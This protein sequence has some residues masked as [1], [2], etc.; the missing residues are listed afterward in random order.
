MEKG[1]SDLGNAQTPPPRLPVARSLRTIEKSVRDTGPIQ[2]SQDVEINVKYVIDLRTIYCFL[3]CICYIEVF[4]N[5]LMLIQCEC[6]ICL[7][8]QRDKLESFFIL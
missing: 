1:I 4:I 2:F 8:S 3:F 6:R 5:K 7:C